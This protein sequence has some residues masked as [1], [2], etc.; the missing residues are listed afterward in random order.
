MIVESHNK[1]GE[2]RRI[3]CTRL[4]VRCPNG[5]PAMVAMQM[6]DEQIWCAHAGE[7]GFERALESMGITD[8]VI[9]HVIEGDQIP[10]PPG[11]LIQPGGR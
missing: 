11:Q 4:I 6:T 10:T 7:P 8:T 2:P 1:F 5:T 9:T 3:E